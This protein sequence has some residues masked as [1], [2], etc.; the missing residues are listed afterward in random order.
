MGLRR[1]IPVPWA[2]ANFHAVFCASGLRWKAIASPAM[3]HAAKKTAYLQGARMQDIH[4]DP[5]EN[6]DL[7]QAPRD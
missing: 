3:V 2:C 4:A 5:F 7:R 6:K 1:R